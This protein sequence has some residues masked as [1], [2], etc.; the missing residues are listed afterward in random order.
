M[1]SRARG[2]GPVEGR[3][4][5]PLVRNGAQPVIREVGVGDAG[6]V[7]VGERGAVPRG[8]VGIR[9][10]LPSGKVMRV[11]RASSSYQQGASPSPA[12]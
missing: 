10:A 5:G 7:G 12:C 9:T 3:A 2:A 1:G 6:F 8:V 4:P 11:S